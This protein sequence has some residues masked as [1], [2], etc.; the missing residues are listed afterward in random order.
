M[1]KLNELITKCVLKN[2]MFAGQLGSNSYNVQDLVHTVNLATIDKMG[3]AI[4]KQISNL[5][6]GTFSK[7][8]NTRQKNEL[9]F[10]YDTL[11]AIYS[12]REGLIEKAKERA[13]LRE[14][15]NRKLVTLTQAKDAQEIERIKSLSPKQLA[16][17]I[18]KAEK[19]AGV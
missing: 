10:K 9:Q 16:K 8:S 1:D 17:E 4:D 13:K 11:A 14:E 2:T 15:A 7:N 5:K 12:Y 19:L 18:V 6:T 3:Q